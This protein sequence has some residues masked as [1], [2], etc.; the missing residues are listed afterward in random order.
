VITSTQ[1]LGKRPQGVRVQREIV[2]TLTEGVIV[3]ACLGLV[4]FVVWRLSHEPTRITKVLLA[5]ASL[6]TAI[7][8]VLM[9]MN[10]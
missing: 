2:T 5:V 10:R 1:W 7:P 9:A 4:G 8:V 6:L 3:L